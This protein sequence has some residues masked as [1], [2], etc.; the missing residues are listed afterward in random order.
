MRDAIDGRG[1]GHHVLEDP[2]PLAEHEVARARRLCF[3]CRPEARSQITFYSRP[4]PTLRT[5]LARLTEASTLQWVATMTLFKV[6]YTCL[7]AMLQKLVRSI[8]VSAYRY[9]DRE[10]VVIRLLVSYPDF[11]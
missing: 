11:F 3:P 7:F 5:T 2:I 4:D 6:P 10:K 1:R 8:Y 9:V